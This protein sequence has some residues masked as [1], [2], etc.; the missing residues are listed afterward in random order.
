ME[1]Q[2][3]LLR[4]LI[5]LKF[6]SIREFARAIDVP[7]TT[8]HTALKRGIGGTAVETVIKMCN[9]V[10]I[11]IDDLLNE[12]FNRLLSP[13]LQALVDNAKHLSPEQL[14]KLNEFIDTLKKN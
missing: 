7:Q 3:E 14:T 6:K 2:T 13:E 11:S 4:H 12:N 5:E 10:G 1:K 8:I 9:G